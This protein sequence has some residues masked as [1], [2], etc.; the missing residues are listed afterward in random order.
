VGKADI[1]V[2][3]TWIDLTIHQLKEDKTIV[4]YESWA[5]L[6]AYS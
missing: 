6:Q 2:S 5:M 3:D 1:M 4:T